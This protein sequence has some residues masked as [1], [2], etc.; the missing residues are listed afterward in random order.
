MYN[1]SIITLREINLIHTT[2]TYADPA[3]AALGS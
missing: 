3:D 2:Y 1:E